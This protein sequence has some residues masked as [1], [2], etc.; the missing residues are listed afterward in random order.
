MEFVSTCFGIDPKRV[1]KG[2]TGVG[3]GDTAEAN[4]P[5]AILK[6]ETQ[7]SLQ[8]RSIARF[9]VKCPYCETENEI[10]GIFSNADKEISGVVC[11]NNECRRHL[12]E[13]FLKNRVT[14]F[15]KELLSF[16]YEGSYKCMEPACENKTRQLAVNS[17]CINGT[18]KGRLTST[19]NEKTTNDTLRYLQGLFNVEKYIQEN[20]KKQDGE[21]VQPLMEDEIPNAA[22]FN[23]LK[24]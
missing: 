4:L 3:S 21:T 22:I 10:R 15:L 23:T 1:N 2:S 18:C 6:S 9:K 19:F 20:P 13:K 12:P 24:E 8:D 16:Y 17:R 14:L 7:K 5:Q 11:Q